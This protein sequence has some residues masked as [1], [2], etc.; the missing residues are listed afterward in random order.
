MV[1][2]DMKTGA[3]HSIGDTPRPALPCSVFVIGPTASGKTALAHAL[4]DALPKLALVNL[5]AFSFYRGV[6]TGTAKP[7]PEEIVRYDYRLVDFLDP[8]DRFDA[9][10][11]AALARAE[12]ENLAVCGRVPLCV[13]GSG[14]YLRALLHGLDELP[15]ANAALREGLR[16]E[17]ADKGWP[18]L[19]AR[20]AEC[21]PVRAA[22]LHPNDATRIE[23]AL[24]VFALSGRP[25]SEQR[26]AGPLDVRDRNEFV[27]QV[28]PDGAWL[29]ERIERRTRAL[30]GE[31]WRAEVESLWTTYGDGLE[32]FQSMQAIG[33]SQMIAAAKAARTQDGRAVDFAALSE[34]I[35]LRTWQYARRQKTWNRKENYDARFRPPEVA[36][37]G[38][39]AGALAREPQV[40]EVVGAVRHFLQTK[41]HTP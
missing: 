15:P 28:D 38:M 14:L 13:G 4:A 11:Y 36:G 12:M 20:L 7:T 30:V 25:M 19:H 33:Y 40:A 24:E 1:S 2:A 26:R 27:A 22:E 34:E 17:A 23:R 5:D 21:D 3:A 16:A 37:G 8:P 18:A 6:S 10:K 29:R 35:A 9:Q 31:D 39:H 32:T 41:G